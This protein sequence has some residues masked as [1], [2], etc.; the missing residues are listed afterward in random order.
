MR[1]ETGQKS[2]DCVAWTRKVRDEM[3]EETKHLSADERLEWLRSRRPTDPVLA[4]MWDNA[5]PP[6]DTRWSDHGTHRV[7]GR[8][9]TRVVIEITHDE[10]SGRYMA[11]ALAGA[12]HAQGGSLDA[13]RANVKQA[14]DQYLDDTAP[15]SRP[16]YIC[17]RFLRDEVIEA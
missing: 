17:M 3:Y 1:D 13:I 4:R 8:E 15:L 5:K 6:P 16:K 11:S 12:I 7:D 14:V 9:E 2:F 10:A